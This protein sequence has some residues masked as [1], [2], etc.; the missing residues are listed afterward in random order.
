MSLISAWFGLIFFEMEDNQFFFKWKMAGTFLFLF[1][2]GKVTLF[3][4]LGK[5]TYF[6]HQSKIT[7][8]PRFHITSK[9]PKICKRK[10]KKIS[11]LMQFG[12][13][14]SYICTFVQRIV[15]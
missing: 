7:I 10:K 2:H 11:R 12:F 8:I 3:F 13:G 1:E 4:R 5:L 9:L 6:C 14:S 15:A